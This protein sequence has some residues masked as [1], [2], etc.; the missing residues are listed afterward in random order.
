MGGAGLK[1]ALYT[2]GLQIHGKIPMKCIVKGQ[3]VSGRSEDRLK[4]GLEA[5][6]SKSLRKAHGES[7]DQSDGFVRG[8]RCLNRLSPGASIDSKGVLP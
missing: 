8:R 2:V 4:L 1:Q 6:A 3:H 5:K 7:L